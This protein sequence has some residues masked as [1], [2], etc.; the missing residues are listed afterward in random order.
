[1]HIHTR[2]NLVEPPNAV[3]KILV[4]I[5]VFLRKNLNREEMLIGHREV[6]QKRHATVDECAP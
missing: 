4:C 2:K 6:F 1:M 5:C 3:I